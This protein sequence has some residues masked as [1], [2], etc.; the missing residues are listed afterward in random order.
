MTFIGNNAK[1]APVV[2]SE[3]EMAEP[4]DPLK[5]TPLDAVVR[6]SD[7]ES[8]PSTPRMPASKGVLPPIDSLRLAKTDAAEPDDPS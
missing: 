7:C 3:T 1:V 5:L 2:E 8:E 6:T 4:L